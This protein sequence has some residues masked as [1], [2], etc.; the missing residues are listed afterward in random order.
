[1]RNGG[2]EGER[3]GGR[4]GGIGKHTCG[5]V[6]VAAEAPLLHQLVGSVQLDHRVRHNVCFL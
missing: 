2:R 4:E 3:E 6:M 5:G 1:M